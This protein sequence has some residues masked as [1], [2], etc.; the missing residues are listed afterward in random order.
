[1]CIRD[2]VYPAQENGHVALEDERIRLTR[3]LFRLP[4]QGPRDLIQLLPM[5]RIVKKR[6]GEI[7]F[8]DQ[9]GKTRGLFRLKD[10]HTAKAGAWR[11]IAVNLIAEGQADIAGAKEARL[12]F[13]GGFHLTVQH[14]DK[15]ILMMHVRYERHINTP[16]DA[17]FRSV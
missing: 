5:A 10:N 7:A 15:F 1:M 3:G 4:Q 12:V 17:E 8:F 2:R 6:A 16:A 14:I 11:V 13:N 9:I